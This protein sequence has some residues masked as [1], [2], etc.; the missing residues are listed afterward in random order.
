MPY[1]PCHYRLG[2]PD[3]CKVEPGERAA[4][5]YWFIIAIIRVQ[6]APGTL[7]INKKMK[8]LMYQDSTEWIFETHRC[9]SC[10]RLLKEA[11]PTS[12]NLVQLEYLASWEYPVMGNVLQG[13]T[14]IACAVVC[15]EC[16]EAKAPIKFAIEYYGRG[17][18]AFSEKIVVYHPIKQLKKIN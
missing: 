3:N 11:G 5:S 2:A 13:T 7:K 16:L 4:R 15:D 9:C 17:A 14:G 12:I 6:K 1:I 18:D 8:K 10:L